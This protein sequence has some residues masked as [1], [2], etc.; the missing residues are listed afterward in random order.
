MWKFLPQDFVTIQLVDSREEWR[1]KWKENLLEVINYPSVEI[2]LLKQRY[3]VSGGGRMLP[4]L[5]LL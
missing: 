2:S 4:V 3:R 5:V 1:S